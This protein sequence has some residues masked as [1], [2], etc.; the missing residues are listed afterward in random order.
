LL[1]V[2]PPAEAAVF[3]A[4]EQFPKVNVPVCHQ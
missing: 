3:P 1:P 4:A 2:G